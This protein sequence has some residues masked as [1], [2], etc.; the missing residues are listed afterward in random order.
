VVLRA[1]AFDRRSRFATA[2]EMAEALANAAPPAS[3]QEVAAWIERV[4]GDLLDTRTQMIREAEARGSMDSAQ[5]SDASADGTAVLTR[6]EKVGRRRSARWPVVLAAVAALGAAGVV[7]ARV[8]R[9]PA[10][11]ASGVL[12]PV[13]AESH[14]SVDPVPPTAL[15]IDPVVSPAV[16]AV[17]S[18][19]VDAGPHAKPGARGAT[20]RPA[21]QVRPPS[22]RAACDPP[23]SIDSDGMKHYK[24]ACLP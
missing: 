21:A 19:S 15:M 13:A 22:A 6:V 8:A 1:A 16:G 9:A 10:H 17:S 14:P 20:S 7:A 2:Q 23:F 12:S 5:V 24:A 3:A 4:G 11:G 18:P